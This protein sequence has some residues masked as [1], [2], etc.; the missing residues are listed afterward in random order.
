M[1]V[2]RECCTAALART[3]PGEATGELIGYPGV[4]T[5]RTRRAGDA[6]A[7]DVVLGERNIGGGTLSLDLLGLVPQWCGELMID[8]C[9]WWAI[10]AHQSGVVTLSSPRRPFRCTA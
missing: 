4:P 9:R 10:S 7:I 2:Q 6:L 3:G 1:T 5:L 8:G